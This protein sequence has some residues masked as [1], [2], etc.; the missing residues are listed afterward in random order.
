MTSAWLRKLAISPLPLPVAWS[1]IPLRLIVGLGFIQHGWAKLMRGP[2]VFIAILHAIGVPWPHVLGWA[3]IVVELTGGT[4]IL[5]GAFVPAA[6]VPMLVVLL[7]AIFTVHLPYGFS[8]INLLSYAGDRAHFGQ[9]GYETDLLY[10]AGLL[11]LCVAGAGPLSI[12]GA[13]RK[14]SARR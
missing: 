1:A 3:T 12:D 9:P 6:T 14:R 8:S 11:A 5:L 2:E 10:I 7:V 13:L 4:L